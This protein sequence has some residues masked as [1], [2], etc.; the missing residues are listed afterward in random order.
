MT[1]TE[2][3]EAALDQAEERGI[4]A[5]VHCAGKGGTVRVVER[6][7]TPARWRRTKA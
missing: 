7:G 3:V 1:D 5:L 4:G 6:D 2:T